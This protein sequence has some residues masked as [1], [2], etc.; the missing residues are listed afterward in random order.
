MEKLYCRARKRTDA[1]PSKDSD[2]TAPSGD[3]EGG[4]RRGGG[5]GREAA[6]LDEEDHQKRLQ[7]HGQKEESHADVC[8][9]ESEGEP[10]TVTHLETKFKSLCIDCRR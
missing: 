8:E 1:A 6:A 4:E 5:G 10:I 7:I 3:R 9:H 2:A